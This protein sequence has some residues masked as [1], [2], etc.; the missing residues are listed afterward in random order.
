MKKILSILFTMALSVG[1]LF[2]FS[3]QAK[4]DLELVCHFKGNG[5]VIIIAVSPRAVPA[6]VAHGDVTTDDPD[7]F[8]AC[9]G[10]PPNPEPCD[11]CE[12]PPGGGG[13]TPP[14]N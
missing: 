10:L 9:L 11:D 3:A 8:E 1:L 6:H 4:P 7:D 5:D 14:I 2:S 13:G 12:P